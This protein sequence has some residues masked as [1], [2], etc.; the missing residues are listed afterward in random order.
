MEIILR[1]APSYQRV[2]TSSSSLLLSHFYRIFFHCSINFSVYF[3]KEYRTNM[4]LM[5]Q[6]RENLTTFFSVFAGLFVIYIVLDWGMDITGRKRGRQLAKS[7]EIGEINGEAIST[8]EFSEL[9]RQAA[10]NQKAQTGSEPDET[11]MRSIRD[12]AWN[13][14]IEGRLY[15]EQVRKLGITVPDKEIYDWLMGENPPEFLTRQFTDSTGNFNRMLYES[16]IKNPSNKARMV[17]LEAA[18]KKQREREKLQSVVLAGVQVPEIDILQRFTDQ[19]IK[20]EGDYI[21]FNPDVLVKDDEVKPTDEDLR[22]S[23]NE[24]SEE[25][26]VEATRKLKYVLF[27]AI[28]SKSDTERVVSLIEDITKRSAAGA[29]FVDLAKTYSES[30]VT[31]SVFEKHGSLSQEKE[32]AIF[33]AKAG[34]ILSPMKEFDGYHLVKVLEFHQGTDEFLHA[35]HI[36]IKTQNND[37]VNALK[38]AR[39]LAAEAKRGVD[40]AELAR[41]N[42]EDKGSGARGGDLGWFGKG[43]MV[44]EFEEAAFKAK[45]GQIV[46]PIKSAFG[47]HII[48]V[49]ARDNRE[50]RIADARLP[51][52]VGTQTKEDVEQRALDF[53][54]LAKQGDFAKE[55]G[56]SKYNVVETPA[57]LKDAAVP[58]IGSNSF[59]NKFA[60]NDKVG[61]VTDVVTLPN[62]FGVFMVSEVKDAGIRPFDELK[63][64]IEAR[65]KRE[66]KMEKARQLASELRQ[67]LSQGDSLQKITLKR[68]DLPVVHLTS[69]TLNAGIPGIGQDL[70]L[71]GGLAALNAGQIS[72]P[73]D[74]LRGVY[75][76]S[77]TSKSAF[78]S[79]TYNTQKDILRNQLLTERKNRFLS[80]WS[81]N[82]KK[83]AEIVDNRDLFYR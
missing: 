78:D 33:S 25:Y 74:G 11:Q 42:S 62:G 3:S 13:Q 22:K 7:Q 70:S 75:L 47:Y 53:S 9:V 69:F 34:D 38:R 44:K 73:I 15:D 59:L 35:S 17:Q 80:D 55:A 31:D 46:G 67:S 64:S 60:F 63:A 21:L 81:E 36:L 54:V 27:N 57:F 58:G 10:D 30:P 40:F 1:R 4:P 66:R 50:V 68:S 82:L 12:Q 41:K 79:T 2:F 39:E 48:K 49:V 14:L 24:H 71:T 43:R 29:D 51:V 28:P 83:S 20:M 65:V 61:T 26:K 16:T 37:S 45:T 77:L 5:T 56:Q 23:Y 52:H 19:N 8:K 32:N 72:K 76:V 18:L 6:I